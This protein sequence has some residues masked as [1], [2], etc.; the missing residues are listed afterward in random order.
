[1]V[2]EQ[3]IEDVL[4]GADSVRL[5][6]LQRCRRLP[7]AQRVRYQAVCRPVAAADDVAGAGAC[8][9]DAALRKES[10]PIAVNQDLGRG[11]AG[12]VGVIASQRIVFTIGAWRHQVPVHLVRRD[13]HGDARPI[14]LTERVEDVERAYDV[15]GEGVE[16]LPIARAHQ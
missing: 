14:G 3:R 1:Q 13:H 11:L 12:T 7:G 15:G 16:R 2:A 5:S 8:Y 9:G 6:Y 4:P 10:L